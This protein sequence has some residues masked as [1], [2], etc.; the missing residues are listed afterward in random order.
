[1]KR[2][3]HQEQLGSFGCLRPCRDTGLLQQLLREQL[4]S[5]FL[6]SEVEG[7]RPCRHTGL[8]QLLLRE[9]LGCTSALVATQGCC[10]WYCEGTWE[11]RRN[12]LG[13]EVLQR[14]VARQRNSVIPVYI[15]DALN[16]APT[17]QT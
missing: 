5:A 13:A 14:G 10:T 11:Q 8:L 16:I 15:F 4:G 12:P 7:L 1:L 6:Y 9:Q 3:P 17:S 2:R